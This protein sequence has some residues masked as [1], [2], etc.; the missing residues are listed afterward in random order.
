MTI[1]ALAL[2]LAACGNEE[3]LENNE[4]GTVGGGNKVPMTFTAGTVQTRTSLAEDGYAVNWTAKDTIAIWDGT[5]TNPFITEETGTIAKFTGEVTEGSTTY[6]AFYPYTK[7]ET[8]QFGDGTIT[9]TLPAEQKAVAGSFDD[10]LNPSWAR[11]TDGSNELTFQNLCALAKFTVGSGALEGITS[12]TLSGNAAGDALAGSLT[13]T[14]ADGTLKAAEEGASRSVTLTG[15]FE[16]G[17]TYYFVV[18]PGTLATGISLQYEDAEGKTYG[19]YTANEVTFAAGKITDLGTL[20]ATGFNELLTNTALVAGLMEYY[21]YAISL[22]ANPDGTAFLNDENKQQMAALTTLDVNS[23]SLTSLAGIEYFT[24]L[25]NLYC[26]KNDLTTLDVSMLTNLEIL[27][28]SNN[29]LESLD[30][31]KLTNLETLNC[32]N[33]SLKSLDVSKLTYL[34]ALNCSNNSLKSLDVSKLTILGEL[35]CNDNGLETLSLPTTSALTTLQCHNN[36]LTAL[37][38]SKLT[39]LTFLTCYNNQM[40]ALDITQNTALEY[41]LCGQQKK[42]EENLT[43]VLTLTKGQESLWSEFSYPNYD[44]NERVTPDYQSTSASATNVSFAGGS[45]VVW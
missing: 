15:T 25:K 14:L 18:A 34:T 27:N 36:A 9:F 2:L 45:K 39:G 13:Y 40:E 43:L 21:D 31:S 1:A 32:S 5:V 42:G 12:L 44:E 3:I 28:C 41:L 33:N 37:D 29:S 6:T 23:C 24:S 16:S 10:D 35:Y 17:K 11:A 38:V 26:H 4:N 19:K 20:E 8:L 7:N 30:V 22:T